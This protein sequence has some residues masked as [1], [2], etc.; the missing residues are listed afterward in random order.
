MVEETSVTSI[1]HYFS[2]VLM[3]DV[4]HTTRILRVSHTIHVS[5]LFTMTSVVQRR[6]PL[7]EGSMFFMWIVFHS[8]TNVKVLQ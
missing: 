1:A 7:E 6:S 4:G 2:C 3:Y 5:T 8:L